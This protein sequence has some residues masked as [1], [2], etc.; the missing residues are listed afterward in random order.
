MPR[1][2]VLWWELEARADKYVKGIADSQ[3][4]TSRFVDFIAGHP[5][6]VMGALATAFIAVGEKAT[7]MAG[8]VEDAM[9]RIG[10]IMPS[11]VGHLEDMKQA[12]FDLAQQVPLSFQTLLS[13]MEQLARL[14]VS[15]PSA[16]VKELGEAARLAAATGTDLNTVITILQRSLQ[17]FNIPVSESARVVDLLMNAVQHGVPL[18]ELEPVMGR[19]AAIASQ[20]G[21]TMDKLVAAIIAMRLAGE[22]TRAIVA[23]LSGGLGELNKGVDG[24]QV[25]MG[26]MATTVQFVNGQIVLTGAGADKFA[27]ILKD[28]N[29]QTGLVADASDRLLHSADGQ[30][31]VVKNQLTQA[32]VNF[33]NALLPIKTTLLSSLAD[34]L[35][36]ISGNS[37][38]AYN[39]EA[40]SAAVLTLKWAQAVD[41]NHTS[42]SSNADDVHMLAERFR[43]LSGAVENGGKITGMSLDQLKALQLQLS[44]MRESFNTEPG[45]LFALQQLGLDPDQAKDAV[46]R[47]LRAINQAIVAA[48]PP[49][50]TKPPLGNTTPHVTIP[51]SVL[52]AQAAAAQQVLDQLGILTQ[53]ANIRMQAEF[54]KL[55]E[56]VAKVF[57]DQ[58]PADVQA[59]LNAIQ[60]AVNQA[61]GEGGLE[62]RFKEL[63]K[64]AADAMQQA[65]SGQGLDGLLNA[66]QQMEFLIQDT[67]REIA[68]SKD[69]PLIQQ[70]LLDLLRQEED[71]R[72]KILGLIGNAGAGEGDITKAI[73]QQVQ[74]LEAQARTIQEAADGGIQLLH[75]FGLISDQTSQ[76][77]QNMVQVGSSIHE[78][79]GII[80]AGGSFSQMLPSILSIAG[81]LGSLISGLFGESPEEKAMK[82]TQQANTEAIQRLTQVIGEF[83]LKVTGQQFTQA[84]VAIS[85]LLEPG[86][87][88][89][90]LKQFTFGKVGA[91]SVD[92]ILAGTGMTLA[93]LQD[94][95]KQLGLTLD[96]T[97][98]FAFTKSLQDLQKAIQETQLTQ[99]A[100][101]FEGQL[102]ALQAQF[103]LFDITDPIQQLQ[104]LAK[105]LSNPAF[106]S[107]GIANALKG[108]D[109]STAAGR[110]AADK[111]IQQLFSQLQAGTLTPAQLGGLT[112]EEFLA[113]LEELH[114]LIDAAKQAAGGST[115]G[116]TSQSFTV[117]QQITEVTADRLA[118]LLEAGNY[119]LQ[120]IEANTRGGPVMQPPANLQPPPSTSTAPA[121]GSG[122]AQINVTV[123]L[124]GL[125]M[126]AQ[127]AGQTI[128]D[129]IVKSIDTALGVTYRR[130][131]LGTGSVLK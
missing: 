34:L 24:V 23:A 101:T 9:L 116:G 56:H 32:W 93:Q 87:Q 72:R 21:V 91:G 104:M 25:G 67:Q 126:A 121:A 83:G 74:L 6:A 39:N 1:I 82:A 37:L 55:A 41:Q 86:T 33:G 88:N 26:R 52:D 89:Q 95:A 62:D 49:T 131:A 130:R 119:W 80:G 47:V 96:T 117:S 13:G 58:I 53:T 48:T 14:G 77:L 97:N 92:A 30:A 90:L 102:Q 100:Q 42:L 111:L 60:R 118:G 127:Q 108:L 43:E 73:D 59:G 54:N 40:S 122:V 8:Q 66:Q 81:G 78:L 124:G 68:A 46:A 50:G 63:G 5:M 61:I 65:T 71:E 29:T 110:D 125:S 22:P 12:L 107:P 28:V 16:A 113:Q 57:N 85:K 129:E 2:D 18:E 44:S 112:P 64:V 123:N 98:V 31:Q 99:F 20:A 69:N 75:S 4:V 103:N 7:E 3:T 11:A 27:G 15:D 106:G 109:L 94:F 70:K 128:G 114:K 84:G 105:L 38:A 35:D 36:R 17:A 76:M 51:Q 19:A 120:L 45:K 79:V 115:T 10:N